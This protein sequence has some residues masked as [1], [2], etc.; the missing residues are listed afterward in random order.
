MQKFL[1]LFLF[2]LFLYAAELHLPVQSVSDNAKSATVNV[3]QIAKGVH[4]FVVRHFT[5]DHSV[6]VADAFVSEFDAA[7]GVATLTLSKYEGLKQNSLPDGNWHVQVGDEVILAFGYSRAILLAPSD[8]I[9]HII[10]KNIR[11][12]EWVHPDN[13]ATYLSYHAHPTPFKEDI[14]GYCTLAEIGLLYTYV[15]NA[16]FT[17]DCQTMSLIQLTP[18]EF[19]EKSVKLPFYSRVEEIATSWWVWGAASR[20]LEAYDPHYLELLVEYNSESKPLYNYINKL[21]TPEQ[22][23]IKKFKIE[24]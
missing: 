8:D 6:I 4:G 19:E 7:A 18:V 13:F 12:V 2:P 5:N 10:T 16:L 21:T 15:N 1:L 24:E 22:K 20:P 23:L 11:G 3:K 9:Y 14:S 17:L